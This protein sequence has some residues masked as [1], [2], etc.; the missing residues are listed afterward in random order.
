MPRE[1][2]TENEAGSE[3]LCKSKGKLSGTFAQQKGSQNRHSGL[4]RVE[5]LDQSTKEN[6]KFTKVLMNRIHRNFKISRKDQ[7]HNLQA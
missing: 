2:A 6:D 3:D 7:I 5:G 4:D 1:T